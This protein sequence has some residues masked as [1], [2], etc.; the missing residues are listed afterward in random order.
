MALPGA[1]ELISRALQLDARMDRR[2]QRQPVAP[3]AHRC[4]A[5]AGDKSPAGA[6]LRQQHGVARQERRLEAERYLVE[7]DH[8]AVAPDTNFGIDFAKFVRRMKRH[9]R[10]PHIGSN[11]DGAAALPRIDPGSGCLRRAGPCP[12]DAGGGTQQPQLIRVRL[13]SAGKGG[14]DKAGGGFAL[15]EQRMTKCV[16]QKRLRGRQPEGRVKSD[17]PATS[18]VSAALRSAPPATAFASSEL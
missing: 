6:G 7:L 10:G 2:C 17:N 4:A 14:L 15:L 8:D 13:P 18:R 12:D 9:S 11:P 16:T 3:D 1:I 5:V